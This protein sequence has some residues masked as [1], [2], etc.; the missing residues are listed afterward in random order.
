LSNAELDNQGIAL[1][2]LATD[3]LSSTRPK[4]NITNCLLRTFI[5]EAQQTS[6]IENWLFGL[7]CYLR[8]LAIAAE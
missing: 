7:R 5:V 2:K 4:A 6:C 3:N 8:A 1:I